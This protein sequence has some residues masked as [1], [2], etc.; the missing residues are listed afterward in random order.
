MRGQQGLALLDSLLA[1]LALGIALAPTVVLIRQTRQ[2]QAENA[3]LS[4]ML[5][6][7]ANLA[8]RMLLAKPDT[9]KAV[10]EKTIHAPQPDDCS[11][12]RF[13]ASGYGSVWRLHAAGCHHRR[14]D[15]E[16]ELP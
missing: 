7:S 3:Y 5:W 14:H 8:E 16:L 11:P 1:L 4:W 12:L 6:H 13:T 15:F 2:A 10:A 9:Y